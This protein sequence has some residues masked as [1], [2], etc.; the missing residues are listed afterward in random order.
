[1]G[2][3]RPT[4]VPEDHGPDVT[5]FDPVQERRVD[6]LRAITALLESWTGKIRVDRYDMVSPMVQQHTDAALLTSIS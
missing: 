6:G 4:W 2:R 5:Y 1:V 3:R